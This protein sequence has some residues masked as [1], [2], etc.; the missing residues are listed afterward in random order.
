MENNYRKL[1]YNTLIELLELKIQNDINV[2]E[3][4]KL[5]KITIL[6][7]I[8]ERT[9][10]TLIPLSPREK[11]V[12]PLLIEGKTSNNIAKT[13]FISTNTVKKHITNILN[14]SGCN[15]RLELIS[16]GINQITNYEKEN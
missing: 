8:G 6:E 3:N 16:Y 7:S 15:N 5:L 9:I 11:E 2:K 14:K 4:L 12:F 1:Y 13:L 10:K